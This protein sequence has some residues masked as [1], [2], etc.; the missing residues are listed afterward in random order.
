MKITR[1]DIAEILAGVGAPGEKLEEKRAAVEAF[2]TENNAKPKNKQGIYVID[3]IK[4]Y[5]EY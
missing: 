4:T 1:Q 5:R 3:E 2:F